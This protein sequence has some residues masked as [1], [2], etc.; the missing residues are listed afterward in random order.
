MKKE[1][2]VERSKERERREEIKRTEVKDSGKWSERVKNR[3]SKMW[4][5]AATTVGVT[6][7]P[8]LSDST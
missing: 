1:Q 7:R 2:K 3:G 5:L 6:L 4:A 8:P